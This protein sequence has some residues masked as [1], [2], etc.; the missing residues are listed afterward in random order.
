MITFDRLRPCPASITTVTAEHGGGIAFE[1]VW[2]APVTRACWMIKTV[3]SPGQLWWS[4]VTNQHGGFNWSLQWANSPV[5]PGYPRLTKVMY[6]PTLWQPPG[7]SRLTWLVKVLPTLA[8]FFEHTHPGDSRLPWFILGL[9]CT[10]LLADAIIFPQSQ[11]LRKQQTNTIVRH[12]A[13]EH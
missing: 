9:W 12:Y 3:R 6:W 13:K 2:S 5:I 7:Y 11:Q 4:H 1:F 8:N 10:Y